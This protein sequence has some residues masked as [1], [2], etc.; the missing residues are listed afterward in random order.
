MPTRYT[1]DPDRHIVYTTFS[2]DA[3]DRD[4]LAHVLAL[5]A[6]PQFRPDMAEL[7]DLTGVTRAHVT[8]SGIRAAAQSLVHARMA[9]RAFIAPSDALFGLTRMYQ[10]Y[11]N[12]GS[13]DRLTI[14]RDRTA[15]LEWLGVA[16]APPARE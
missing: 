10:S 5:E 4:L 3:S 16:N 1:I 9:R 13:D 7:V 8:S 12:N 11:W 6:D 14:F 2:G 15:A